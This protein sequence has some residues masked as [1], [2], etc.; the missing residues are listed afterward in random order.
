MKA[1]TN[2]KNHFKRNESEYEYMHYL[3]MNDPPFTYF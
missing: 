1:N 3:Y 2:V